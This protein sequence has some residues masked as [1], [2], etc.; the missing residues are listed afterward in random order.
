MVCTISP[1]QKPPM[2]PIRP[3]L[4][5]LS[6]LYPFIASPSKPGVLN[7]SATD[8]QGQFILCCGRLFCAL[9]NAEQYPYLL[10]LG[11]RNNL[12]L[13]THAPVCAQLCLCHPMDC[14]APLCGISQQEYRISFSRGS[15]TPRDQ[16]CVSCIAAGLFTTE[17]TGKA[18]PQIVT[19][20]NVSR[21][22]AKCSPESKTVPLHDPC[23][24][25]S[26]LL[27]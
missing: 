9:Q 8:I 18:L 23:S 22:F 5:N 13:P 4:N 12:P 15:F 17:P 19:I 3:V 26:E 6:L 2:V 16:T 1:A 10:S 25:P 24:L 7:L 14:Q 11:A 21:H 20:K 27:I